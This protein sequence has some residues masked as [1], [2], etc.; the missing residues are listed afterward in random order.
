MKNILCLFI[1]CFLFFTDFV[2][3]QSFK[4]GIS[5][6]ISTSQISGDTHGGFDKPG[7]TGGGFVK[8]DFTG[9]YSGQLEIN[10][11]QKGARKS[12]RPEQGDYTFYLLRLNY[13][14][15]PILIKYKH[16]HFI[17][18]AGPSLAAL[19]SFTEENEQGE[20]PQSREFYKYEAGFAIGINYH[21]TDKL[22]MNWRLTNSVLPV[23]SHLSGAT[24]RWN[25]GQYNSVLAFTLHYQFN[26]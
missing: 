5:A 18:E 12:I 7:I 1:L 8:Y 11:I 22:Y 6:G 16:K 13:I 4:G 19:L 3:S 23:R 20:L 2:Q 14:E 10:Y 9:I 25:R 15:V 26:K 24:Y 21:F 17:F